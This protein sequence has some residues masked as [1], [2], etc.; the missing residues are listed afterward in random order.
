VNNKGFGSI[1]KSDNDSSLALFEVEFNAL[2]IEQFIS[3]SVAY[4]DFTIIDHLFDEAITLSPIPNDNRLRGP[5]V[6]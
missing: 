4:S 5:P 6:A 3:L 1:E 2:E